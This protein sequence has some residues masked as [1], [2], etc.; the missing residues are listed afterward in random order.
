MCDS[1]A[2]SVRTAGPGDLAA[3]V[4]IENRSFSDPWSPGALLDELEADGLRLPLV[5]ERG[6]QVV[7]FLMAWRVADQLHVLNVAADPRHLRRGIGTAMLRE[8]A[9]R[10]CALGLVEATLEVRRSNLQGRAFYR[11]H[12][13]RETG[14]RARYYVDNGEDAIILDCDLAD[15]ADP[16]GD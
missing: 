13:F 6:G 16:A 12:G 5:A 10:G 14:V 4:S 9:R 3:V 1:A 15:L 11:R 2:I 7:G 8:A